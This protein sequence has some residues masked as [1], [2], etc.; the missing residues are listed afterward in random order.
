MRRGGVGRPRVAIVGAGITGLG[1]AHRLAPTCDVVLFEA[2]AV[3]GGHAHSVDV[4]LDGITY[5]VDVGFL[6][7]NHRTYPRLLALFDDLKVKTALS[8]MSFAVS[9]GPHDLEWCGKDDLRA[10]FAQPRNLLRPRFWG[11]LR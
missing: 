3:A 6:V 7:F 4:T 10:L 2:T 11:M 9:I 8:N 1:A 5:P